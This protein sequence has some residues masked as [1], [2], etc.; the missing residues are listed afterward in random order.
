MSKEIALKPDLLPANKLTNEEIAA[1]LEY[2]PMIESWCKDIKAAAMQRAE[3]GDEIPGHKLVEGR[4]V[5]KWKDEQLVRDTLEAHGYTPEQFV[6]TKLVGVTAVEKLL[7]G[8]KEAAPVMQ[9][10]TIKPEGKPTL[11]PQS[12]KREAISSGPEADFS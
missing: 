9:E 5:R 10:L 12:D 1:R 3:S 6:T 2:I 4:S 8:K 7:G 11:V